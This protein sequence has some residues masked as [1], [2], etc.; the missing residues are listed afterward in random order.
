MSSERQSYSNN[1]K[2]TVL[3]DYEKGVIGYGFVALSAKYNVPVETFRGW[4]E[5]EDQ[6]KAAAKNRQVAIRVSRWFRLSGAGH[7]PA[8]SEVKE[9][10]YEWVTARNA[11]DLRVKDAHIR[12]QAMNISRLRIVTTLPALRPLQAA[13]PGS[14]DAE[15]SSPAARQR[16]NRFQLMH[17]RSTVN[18]FSR[19]STSSKKHNI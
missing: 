1:E 10:L 15:T 8:R 12:P 4:H 17:L 5:V 11:K 13:C 2:L 7:K 9:R 3:A 18:S 6:L 19:P 14:R 16:H